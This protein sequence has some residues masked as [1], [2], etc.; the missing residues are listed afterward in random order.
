MKG[1][2]TQR[3]LSI[4]WTI[5]AIQSIVWI[6][7]NIININLLLTEYTF[8][9]VFILACISFFV[10]ILSINE[11]LTK[12]KHIVNKE[13]AKQRNVKDVYRYQQL[14]DPPDTDMYN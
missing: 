1:K 5:L 2:R 11:L 3:V 4:F 10:S 12:V 9:F 13:N 8:Q 7:F 6:I 14:L